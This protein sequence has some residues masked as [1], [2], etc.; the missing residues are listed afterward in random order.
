M[1]K[2]LR[3]AGASVAEAAKTRYGKE[4]ALRDTDVYL[5]FVVLA[6]GPRIE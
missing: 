6:T 5:R 3:E 2:I 4:E 1:V